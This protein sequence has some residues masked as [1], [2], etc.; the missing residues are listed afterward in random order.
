MIY[1]ARKFNSRE[2]DKYDSWAKDIVSGFLESRGHYI[3]SSEEDYNHDLVTKRCNQ[4]YY[5]ELEV[6]VGYPFTSDQDYRFDTVSFLGRKR[7][8]HDIKPF[9]YVIIC[10]ETS[11]ALYCASDVIYDDNHI[12]YVSVNSE[13]R[14][15]NDKMYRVPVNKCGFFNL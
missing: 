5:F 6:K 10:K 3:I 15:G 4:L 14:T 11:A 9:F 2:Y 13:N 8:L 1:S 7:R 12:E